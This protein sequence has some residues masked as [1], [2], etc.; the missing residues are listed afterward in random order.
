MEI[1][2]AIAEYFKTTNKINTVIS[3]SKC[4]VGGELEFFSL[5]ELDNKLRYL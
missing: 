1:G 2:Q 4:G 3:H 5:K